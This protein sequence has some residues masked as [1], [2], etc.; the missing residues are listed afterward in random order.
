MNISAVQ[1]L[2]MYSLH[3]ADF[4]HFPTKTLKV[5]FFLNVESTFSK[6]ERE[7]RQCEK[8]HCDRGDWAHK[9]LS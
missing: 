5:F 3:L 6:K 2:L 1:L 9:A 4:S 8:G 7:V